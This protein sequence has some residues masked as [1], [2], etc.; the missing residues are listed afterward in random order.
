MP[1]VTELHLNAEE[2]ADGERGHGKIRALPPHANMPETQA[3]QRRAD[4]GRQHQQGN[5]QIAELLQQQ[6]RRIGREAE[7]RRMAE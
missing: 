4:R 1:P 6:R 3:E 5:G 7:E 2:R